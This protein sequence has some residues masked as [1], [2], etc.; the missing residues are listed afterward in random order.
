MSCN[1]GNIP[2]DD[3][4]LN[5]NALITGE[6]IIGSYLINDTKIWIIADP[7]NEKGIRKAITVLLPEEY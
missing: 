1:W 5:N 3:K 4:A 2:D 6:R 7:E